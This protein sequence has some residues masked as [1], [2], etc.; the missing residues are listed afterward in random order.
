[1]VKLPD[2]AA[3]LHVVAGDVTLD[4]VVL[5]AG[6]GAGITAERSVSLTARESSEILLFDIASSERAV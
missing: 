2:H 5:V 3:W 4:D 1:L 6:D